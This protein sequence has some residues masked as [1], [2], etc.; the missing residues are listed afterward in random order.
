MKNELEKGRIKNL[1]CKHKDADD[2]TV[3]LLIHP[4]SLNLQRMTSFAFLFTDMLV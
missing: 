4:R 2:L 3:S 1:L